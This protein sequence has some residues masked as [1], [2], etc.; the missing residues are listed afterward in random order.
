MGT[1]ARRATAVGRRLGRGA[2]T[3]VSGRLARSRP[4]ARVGH[5]T[6]A[7]G[8]GCGARRRHPRPPPLRDHCGQRSPRV[9]HLR[10]SSPPPYPDRR[11]GRRRGCRCSRLGRW[12][13]GRSRCGRCRGCRR[14]GWRGRR[15]GLG[16]RRSATRRCRLGLG[17]ALG[18]RFGFG[19]ALVGV[20]AGLA[21]RDLLEDGFGVRARVG[22]IGRRHL[23]GRRVVGLR[24]RGRLHGLRR[25]RRRFGF[26]VR[27]RVLVLL[28][29]RRRG[30]RG[31][32]GRRGRST[33]AGDC[34]S[35]RLVRARRAGG[36]RQRRS[37][38]PVRRRQRPT[39]PERAGDARRGTRARRPV[40]PGRRRRP[41]AAA[42]PQRARHRSRP[43]LRAP[44]ETRRW[45]RPPPLPRRRPP[46]RPRRADAASAAAG[47]PV[48]AGRLGRRARRSPVGPA[49]VREAL[50][51]HRPA[52][53][54]RGGLSSD[55]GRDRAVS[56]AG[57]AGAQVHH[58]GAAAAAGAFHEA[59]DRAVAGGL[60]EPEQLLH[61][62]VGAGRRQAGQ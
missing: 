37:D 8:R 53:P 24:G 41:R 50:G 15:R 34:R 46:A 9:Q 18:L 32:L 1:V 12:G 40:Q 16:L 35:G 42:P 57:R 6:A 14:C 31:H 45:H 27:R 49:A 10:R 61:A 3:D 33:T 13:R 59:V 20:L 30:R 39:G 60:L 23:D 47:S 19:A 62:H 43:R 54:A 4:G 7:V 17:F 36:L 26:A 11:S 25:R 44:P 29:A 38:R 22:R 21:R 2:A 58:A 52:L 48:R 55:R 51:G 28:G 56:T 5:G